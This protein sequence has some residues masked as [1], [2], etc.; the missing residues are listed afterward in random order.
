[1]SFKK[2]SSTSEIK[3]K[4]VKGAVSY[5]IRT[6]FLQTIGLVAMIILSRLF[7]PEEFGIYGF[8]VMIIGLLTFVSDIGLAAALIQ[9]PSDPS[10]SDYR[11]VFTVQLLLGMILVV[12]ALMIVKLNLISGKTGAAGNWVLLA[13]AISFPLATLK[14][15]PSVVLERKLEFNKLVYPQIAEQL[16]FNSILIFLAWNS[17][18]ATAYAVAI[19][20]RSILGVIILNVL[21]PWPIGLTIDRRSFRNLFKFGVLFQ[22]NDLLA[23]VKDQL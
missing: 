7:G 17:W 4:S 5:F 22:V 10:I 15:I 6:A 23:R 1:M 8:V 3:K 12:V 20:T 9:K 2:D 11:T 21:Q 16:A 18:D 13:M 14:T 19:L